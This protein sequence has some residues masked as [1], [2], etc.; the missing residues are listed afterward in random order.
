[1]LCDTCSKLFF[2][3]KN[4]NCMRCNGLVMINL[5]VLCDFCSA[6]EK[7]CSFCLKKVISQQD[8]NINSGCNCGKS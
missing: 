2:I 7:Q 5:S 4:K 6:T 8:R 1:M 3:F